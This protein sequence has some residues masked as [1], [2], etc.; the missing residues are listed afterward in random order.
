MTNYQ[1]DMARVHV[2]ELRRRSL[3]ARLA[4]AT[5]CR[6]SYGQRQPLQMRTSQRSWSM[7]LLPDTPA[8]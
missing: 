1:P 3:T 2:Q 8:T 6:S 5:A 4:D 7:Y